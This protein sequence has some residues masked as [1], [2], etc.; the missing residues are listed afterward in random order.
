MSRSSDSDVPPSPEPADDHDSIIPGL[1]PVQPDRQ[2]LAPG[3]DMAASGDLG[4]RKGGRGW[5]LAFAGGG[6]ALVVVAAVLVLSHHGGQPGTAAA[7]TG[8]A[9]T[10]PGQ[11]R[12]AAGQSPQSR[13]SAPASQA[14][15][16]PS[17]PNG[18]S[19]TTTGRG[20]TSQ[21][22]PA[23]TGSTPA[24][25]VAAPTTIRPP[26]SQPPA[27]P[28]DPGTSGELP[29]LA[30]PPASPTDP[31]NPAPP[32]PADRTVSVSRGPAIQPAT[33][34]CTGGVVCYSFNVSVADFP[35]HAALAYTCAD[36]GGVWWGPTS[37][38]NSGTIVTNSSGEASFITYCVHPLDGAT[39]TINVGGGG[40][41][42][43]GKYTTQR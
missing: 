19:V 24:T 29:P 42:A 14:G 20:S 43:S 41:S 16:L 18:A 35:A 2:D 5:M 11:A 13:Q 28:V 40:L 8:Q 3:A 17:A 27:A 36:G 15:A 34:T 4:P 25:P 26:R 31:P 33:G 37:T 12:A 9:T 23:H 30:E 10:A 1:E 21:P 38:V 32:V 6:V 7:G 39:I 22:P